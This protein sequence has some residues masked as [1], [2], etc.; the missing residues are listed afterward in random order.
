MSW[1]YEKGKI[2]R[3]EQFPEQAVG[4]VYRIVHIPTGKQY[5]G[6]KI[7]E[8][9]RRVPML[10]RELAEWDKPGRKPKKKTVV[11]ESDW[12]DY[13]SSNKWIKEQI[14]AGKK[15]EFTRE[16]IKMCTS[17]KQL[18]YYE[19]KYQF[20]ENVLESDRYLNDNILGKF[21]SVDV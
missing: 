5:I 1:K 17:K 16:I 7:L 8:S 2:D 20:S 21:Y 4:F 15:N 14:K 6:K 9:T 12:K 10:K 19:A 11:K 18:S 3:I 13:Y